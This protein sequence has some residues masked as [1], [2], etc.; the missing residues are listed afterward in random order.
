MARTKLTT[1]NMIRT[2]TWVLVFGDLLAAAGVFAVTTVVL[3]VI[4]GG[5]VV[6]FKHFSS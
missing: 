4:A 5:V 1:I 3:F 6:I 2:K